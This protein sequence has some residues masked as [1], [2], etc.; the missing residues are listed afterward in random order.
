MLRYS[1]FSLIALSASYRERRKT[2]AASD[3]AENDFRSRHIF[4]RKGGFDD[5]MSW[6]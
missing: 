5:E 2:S 4:G 6:E 1:R 3:Y